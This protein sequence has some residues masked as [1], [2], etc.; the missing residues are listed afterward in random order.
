MPSAPNPQPHPC[1]P[2]SPLNPRWLPLQCALKALP[3]QTLRWLELRQMPPH[4]WQVFSGSSLMWRSARYCFLHWCLPLARGR[5]RPCAQQPLGLTPMPSNLLPRQH[6]FFRGP[7]A[8]LKGLLSSSGRFSDPHE[9]A[10]PAALL[11]STD[12]RNTFHF[13]HFSVR[14][15]SYPKGAQLCWI[16]EHEFLPEK[17]LRVCSP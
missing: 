10:A 8:T 6:C 4:S 16:Q 5:H 12:A 2:R 15:C 3:V 1:T 17:G 14:V 11:L 9:A 13:C 7:S